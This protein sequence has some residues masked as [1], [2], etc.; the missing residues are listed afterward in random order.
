[1][2]DA[3]YRHLVRREGAKIK[4]VKYSASVTKK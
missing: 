4:V 3:Y 1:M 2:M